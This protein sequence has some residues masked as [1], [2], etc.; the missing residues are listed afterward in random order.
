MDLTVRLQAGKHDPV[1][2]ISQHFG[3]DPLTLVLL[4]VSN[5]ATF[6]CLLSLPATDTLCGRWR[7]QTW[8][9]IRW[10]EPLCQWG[11]ERNPGGQQGMVFWMNST[12]LTGLQ[13]WFPAC[14]NTRRRSL[15]EEKWERFEKAHS[16]I[17][18]SFYFSY[19]HGVISVMF[20]YHRT[21]KKW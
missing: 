12:T 5:T 2:W 17:S 10:A 15:L 13:V 21:D 11:K 6:F 3:S 18:V 8:R 9:P 16:D 20:Q 4:T 7:L 19:K 1:I 14:N